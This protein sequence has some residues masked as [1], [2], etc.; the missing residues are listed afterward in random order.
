MSYFKVWPANRQKKKLI[1][2]A[3]ADNIFTNLLEK[4][5]TKFQNGETKLV[6]EYD[7]TEIDE[8]DEGLRHLANKGEVLLLLADE[9]IWEEFL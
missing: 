9:E 5:S 1:F 7:G 6:F 2:I 4:C 3:T 8:D